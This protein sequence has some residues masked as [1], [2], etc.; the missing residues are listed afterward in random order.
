MTTIVFRDGILTADGNSYRNNTRVFTNKAKIHRLANGDL[1]GSAGTSSALQGFIAWLNGDG[2]LAKRPP[3]DD[4]SIVLFR[5][6]DPRIRI[7]ESGGYE[8]L[9][10][11]PYF[12]IGSGQEFAYGALFMG[13][14]AEQAL[15]AAIRHDPWTGGDVT[16]LRFDEVEPR[17]KAV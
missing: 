15:D 3:T 12:A 17:L 8:D 16:V 13:A 9:N 4:A 14:N 6:G 2:D 1:I 11:Q 10:P 7:F 5:R